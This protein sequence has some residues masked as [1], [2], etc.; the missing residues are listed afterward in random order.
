VGCVKGGVHLHVAVA[1]KV[2]DHDH[3]YDYDYDYVPAAS[4][5]EELGQVARAVQRSVL[6]DSATTSC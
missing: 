4:L 2:H 5:E 3:D 1:V 6:R